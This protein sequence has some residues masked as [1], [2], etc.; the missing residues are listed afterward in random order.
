MNSGTI[1]LAVARKCQARNAQCQDGCG[2]RPGPI[3]LDKA[4]QDLLKLLGL[5]LDRHNIGPWLLVKG[6][7]RPARRLKY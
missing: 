6:R 7:R 2:L 4:G 3:E 1:D 5:R